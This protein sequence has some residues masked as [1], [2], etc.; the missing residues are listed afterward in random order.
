L[1]FLRGY[2]FRTE[3]DD[4]GSVEAE[5]RT[6]PHSRLGQ[7][8]LQPRAFLLEERIDVA[9]AEAAGQYDVERPAGHNGDSGVPRSRRLADAHRVEPAADCKRMRRQL[10]HSGQ[11]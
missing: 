4:T 8:P 1:D 9:W 5:P 2:R 11:P 6:R 3:P 10:T 7:L